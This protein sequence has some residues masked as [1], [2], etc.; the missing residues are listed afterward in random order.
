LKH[1]HAGYDGQSESTTPCEQ[2]RERD[3]YENRA[4]RFG[5]DKVSQVLGVAA[6]Q[7]GADRIAFDIQDERTV[8]SDQVGVVGGNQSDGSNAT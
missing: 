1:R 2:H 8:N 6:D 7:Y 5:D 4:R 3:E